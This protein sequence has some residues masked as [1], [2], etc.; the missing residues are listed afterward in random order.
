MKIVAYNKCSLIDYPGYISSV[1]F[2]PYCN[3]CCEFCH[4]KELLCSK[5]YIEP[6]VV[7]RHLKNSK[8]LEAIVISG[9]EPTIQ[10]EEL[11]AFLYEIHRQKELE[12]GALPAD[13]KIKLDTNGS[14]P[15][16][17]EK[18]LKAQLVDYV[19]MD[20]K[21]KPE[22]YVK[23]SG[24]AFDEVKKSLTLLRQFGSYELRTTAYPKITLV[25]LEELCKTYQNENYYLQQYRPVSADS[26]APYDDSILAEMALKYH[27]G[28][29][30][31][32]TFPF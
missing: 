7:F 10:G 27:V 20:I 4:N 29:R 8:M 11:I 18:I 21:T 30:G 12:E 3:M 23:I 19:A 16:V 24:L 31:I 28:L 14:N 15:H 13:F 25:Q 32:Q 5:K 9:G 2:T 6:S 1:V 26:P 17:L 22:D